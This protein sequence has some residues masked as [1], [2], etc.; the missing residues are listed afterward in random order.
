MIYIDNFCE[1]VRQIIDAARGG[2]FFPQNEEYV[3]TKDVIVKARKL[4]GHRTWILPCPQFIIKQL[5]K[6]ETFN[7]AFGSKIYDKALYGYRKYNIVSFHDSL[8]RTGGYVK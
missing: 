5:S 8:A 1:C 7:K 2:I 4:A 6:N 3:S